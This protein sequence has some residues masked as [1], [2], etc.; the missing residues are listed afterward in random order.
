MV[1]REVAHQ[2][3]FTLV[4]PAKID[5]IIREKYRLDY[6]LSGQLSGAP[7]DNRTS[8]V[9]ANLIGAILTDMSVLNDLVVL[10][11]EASSS[12]GPSQTRSASG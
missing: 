4:T 1:A 11:G 8:K 10:E 5:E 2:L 6:S 12:S 3:G 9:F 7:T